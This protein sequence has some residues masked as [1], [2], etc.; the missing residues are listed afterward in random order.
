M[1]KIAAGSH[2]RGRHPTLTLVAARRRGRR[3][4][5]GGGRRPSS[6]PLP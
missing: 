5:T 1:F 3:C 4:T 6:G 2:E